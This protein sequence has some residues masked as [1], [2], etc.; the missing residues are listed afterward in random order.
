[1]T[2]FF[3]F[4]GITVLILVI[5]IISYNSLIRL[6]QKKDEAFSGITV[7]MKKRYDLIPQL[8]KTVKAYAK[9][10]QET[11]DKVVKARQQAVDF[12]SLSE[13]SIPED[14]VQIAKTEET[15]SN[16]LNGLFALA[17][18][19]PDLKSSQNFL[20]LQNE[21]EEIEDQI[22]ASRRIYNSN[23]Q[24]YNTQCEVFPSNIIAKIF[25][26][27]KSAYFEVSD[28]EQKKIQNMPEMN[29]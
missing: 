9:F 8:I 4:V 26:F 21:M 11:L 14:F 16:S 22:S 5:G 17:E 1:M 28:E 3:I 7:Q 23:T 25:Q 24:F 13:K 27:K 20:D 18:N 12:S 19:Y 29:F 15:L 6:R 10:E 2:P